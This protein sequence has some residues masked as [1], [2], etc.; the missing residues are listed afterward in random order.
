MSEAMVERVAQAIYDRCNHWDHDDH[1][2]AY[3]TLTDGWKAQWQDAARSAIKANDTDRLTA[4]EAAVRKLVDIVNVYLPP[5]TKMT[6][7]EFISEVIGAVDNPDVF[8]AM[9]GLGK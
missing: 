3:S 5:D 6:A 9:R 1:L 4:L 2:P 8:R 7:D